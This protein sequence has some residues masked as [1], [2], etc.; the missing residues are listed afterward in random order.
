MS[1]SDR[2]GL[3]IASQLAQRHDIKVTLRPSVYGGTTAIVLIPTALVVEADSY[4]R[5]PALT[6]GPQS[7]RLAGR[8]ALG[9]EADRNGVGRTITEVDP[10]YAG[11]SLAI[12][13]QTIAE[14]VEPTADSAEASAFGPASSGL[15]VRSANGAF[16]SRAFEAQASGDFESRPFEMPEP[17]AFDAAGPSRP[18]PMADGTRGPG[19]VGTPEPGGFGTP[20]PTDGGVPERMVLG[21]PVSD[22]D[23]RVTAAEVTDVGLPVRVRQASL[24]PQ[25][26]NAGQAR[27]A[28]FGPAGLR[29]VGNPS[30][31]DPSAGS[32]T[33]TGSADSS[34]EGTGTSGP[35]QA[36]SAPPRGID[37]FAAANR[38]TDPAVSPE[39]ARNTV[40]ALQRGWQLGRSEAAAMK[41]PLPSTGDSD[42][43][44][45]PADPDLISDGDERRTD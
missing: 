10:G 25:L 20:E 9:A 15:P 29:A 3:F 37:V 39:A 40:S 36:G 32:T 26:R 28:S 27:P 43:A 19:G 18:G 30:G 13:S 45:E 44:A 17:S 16:A 4:E 21:S 33:G 6:A 2:L 31:V 12:G 35:D 11:T 22:H 14:L 7:G 5:D 8:H 41:P 24:A 23:P 34:A 38:P 42:T 1:G